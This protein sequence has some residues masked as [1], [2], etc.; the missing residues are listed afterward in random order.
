[1]LIRKRNGMEV[2][3][4]KGKIIDS[5]T[6]G[7]KSIH[8]GN[9]TVD[10]IRDIAN[11]TEDH[12]KKLDNTFSVED[13]QD[14][15]ETELIKRGHVTLAKH[16]ITYRY[17]H[18]VYRSDN[19]TSTDKIE[20]LLDG[21]NR[22]VTND[23]SNKSPIHH[24]VARDY[25]AGFS[26]KELAKKFIPEDIMDAHND[27]IIHFHD[28]DYSPA[29]RMHNC[30]LLDINDMLQNGTEMGG[31]YIHKPHSL[32]TAMT[33]VSQISMNISASQYGGQTISLSHVAPFVDVSR[34]RIKKELK[35][36]FPKNIYSGDKPYDR[37]ISDITEDQLRLEIKSAVQTL[38]YQEITC[39]SSNGQSPFI[40]VFMYLGEV[41]DK[42]TKKDLALLIEEVLKQ[43]IKGIQAPDGSWVAPVFPKLIYVLEEDNIHEDSKYYYLT[44]LARDCV[45]KRMVP[46]FVS[47]KVMLKL[48]YGIDNQTGKVVPGYEHVFKNWMLQLGYSEKDIDD[49]INRELNNQ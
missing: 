15:I 13:V 39:A 21:V 16:Y 26:C 1:M 27:G 31:T 5:L 36:R 19:L 25:I 6:K 33:I 32:S 48:R 37:F 45:M 3:F 49:E 38:Q 40:T 42:R 8:S 24:N 12:F 28:M 18:S 35:Q 41:S 11:K 10:E 47:E 23:N 30:A 20:T 14:H 46:D 9:I 34:K 44:K 17:K 43:R 7:N 29:M 22:E 4:K 2:E